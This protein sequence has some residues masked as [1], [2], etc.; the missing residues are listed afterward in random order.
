MKIRILN[1]VVHHQGALAVYSMS[2]S[3]T[4]SVWLGGVPNKACRSFEQS[5][6]PS[7]GRLSSPVGLA[8]RFYPAA[9]RT[10]HDGW[11]DVTMSSVLGP[12]S[13]VTPRGVHL[14]IFFLHGTSGQPFPS[15]ECQ[16]CHRPGA[17]LYSHCQA[18]SG[19]RGPQ[20]HGAVRA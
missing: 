2:L 15:T 5:I 4:N 13:I 11:V 12:T 10:R 16:G 19:C 8:I 1:T 6:L 18:R 3:K 7:N 14:L 20:Q 17:H 9:R